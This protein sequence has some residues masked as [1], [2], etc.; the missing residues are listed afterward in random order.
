MNPGLLISSSILDEYNI[1][2][3]IVK[4]DDPQDLSSINDYLS[5]D[6]VFVG[7]SCTCSWEYLE[8]LKI[9]QEIKKINK[10]ITTVISGW[11]VKSIKTKIFD[12]SNDIDY[13]IMGDAEN[14]VIKLY[15]TITSNNLEDIPTVIGRNQFQRRTE[16]RTTP[17][18]KFRAIDFSKFPNYEEYIPYAEESRNCPYNCQFCLNSCVVDKYQSV[19]FEIFK[20]NVDNIE[21]VYG[22][23]TNANL[24]AANFGV[25]YDGTKKKIE[26][27]KSKNLKWNIELHVNNP[28]E[29]YID[30]FKEAGINKVSIGFESGS[31]TILKLMKKTENPEQYLQN[32]EQLL[33]KLKEYEIPVNLNI[34]FDYRETKETISETLTFLEKNKSLFSKAKANFMFAFEGVLQNIDL[35]DCPN[36]IIDEYGKKIHAYPILPKNFT[37]EEMANLIQAL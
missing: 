20:Q 5:N 29:Y 3:K 30:D 35:N 10:N 25:N 27:L 7:I 1:D 2:N 17:E 12:D 28:W 36:I 9:A 15:N 33:L 23:A 19:P 22:E 14:T 37:M 6:I 18:I 16:L 34:L 21:K 8:S 11:Q 26:Y 32:T 24:L 31:P 4:I 13:I